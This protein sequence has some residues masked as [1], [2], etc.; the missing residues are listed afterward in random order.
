MEPQLEPTSYPS[1]YYTAPWRKARICARF[2]L[3]PELVRRER[4]ARIASA[5]VNDASVTNRLIDQAIAH[6]K[7]KR[8]QRGLAT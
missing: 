7:G 8:Y 4:Y 2:V 1:G 5:L 6:L 3:R